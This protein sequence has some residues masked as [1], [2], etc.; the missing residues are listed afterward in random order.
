MAN[1]STNKVVELELLEAQACIER[2]VRALRDR[3]EKLKG[4]GDPDKFYGR[5]ADRIEHQALAIFPEARVE[6]CCQRYENTLKEIYLDIDD[7]ELDVARPKLITLQRH[8]GN[9]SAG[10]RSVIEPELVYT[11]S[12]IA[13]LDNAA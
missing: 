2:A 1:E 13:F 4:D 5:W 8:I 7:S 9:C 10:V 6:G 12:L 11:E 3:Q